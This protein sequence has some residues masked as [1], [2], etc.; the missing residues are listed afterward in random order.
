MPYAVLNDIES[1]F[2]NIVFDENSAVTAEEVSA[3]IDQEESII[4][5]TISNRY[6]VP[7]A[8]PESVKVLRGISTAFVAYRVAKIVNIKK[9]IP[10]P[11]NMISQ[12][13]N[14]GTRRAIAG[15][16]LRDIQGGKM[17]LSDAMSLSAGQGV[18]SHNSKNSVGSI[19]KRDTK[20][21]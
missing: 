6:V 20:Q 13:I 19:W 11:S 9:D 12:S 18:T 16:Q 14:D 7:V 21:W 2:K 1:E 8:G 15:K 17:I 5:A 4:N 3:F 10:I